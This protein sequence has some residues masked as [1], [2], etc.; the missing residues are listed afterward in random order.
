MQWCIGRK[1]ERVEMISM[2]IIGSIFVGA[3]L[4]TSGIAVAQAPDGHGHEAHGASDA[5]LKL[6]SGE[7]W[8]TDAP[9]RANI[10]LIRDDLAAMMGSI[11]DG[12]FTAAQYTDLAGRIEK[13]L[14]SMIA[15]CKL[16]PDADAQLHVLLVDFFAGVNAMKGDEN[17]MQ[18]A[19]K[20]VRGLEA[21][22]TYFDH[23]DWKPLAH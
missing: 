2:R 21:Y 18:G 9:L 20:I 4:L 5:K 7:K 23:P 1:G 8:K 15:Q 16:P 6:N 19:V 17:R 12:S 13:H 14:L 3:T 11:H 22:S 10:T